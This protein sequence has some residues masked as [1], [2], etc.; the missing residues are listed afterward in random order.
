MQEEGS[1]GIEL[2][3]AL[4]DVGDD[5]DGKL[6]A[7]A[8]VDA[9]DAH[10]VLARAERACNGKVGVTLAQILEETQEAEEAAVI[11]L[12]VLCRAVGEHAQVR[13]AQQA[14]LE[15]ADVIVVA[16]LA[17]ERPDE[18]RHAVAYGVAAPAVERGT[19]VGRAVG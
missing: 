19:E 4:G 1:P 2:V 7:L 8:L 6:E 3:E 18:L 12:L 14:A 11:R 10:D 9:H 15:A 13:L 17:V 16:C 5:D